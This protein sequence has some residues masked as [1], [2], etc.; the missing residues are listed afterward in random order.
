M[1]VVLFVAVCSWRLASLLFTAFAI[2]NASF[3]PWTLAAR[4]HAPQIRARLTSPGLTTHSI[5][6]HQG[7][8]DALVARR[9]GFAPCIYQSSRIPSRALA[10]PRPRRA[11]HGAHWATR[12]VTLRAR[13]STRPWRPGSK[14]TAPDAFLPVAP[15]ESAPEAVRKQPIPDGD[16][17]PHPQSPAQRCAVRVRALIGPRPAADVEGVRAQDQ[18]CSTQRAM[19]T[20]RDGSTATCAQ[21]AQRPLPR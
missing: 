19:S 3:F 6:G 10:G 12:A 4:G 13:S 9:S 16:G 15:S 2:E 20:A 7:L 14:L 21:A 5:H 17:H 1:V 11:L 18:H 8:T